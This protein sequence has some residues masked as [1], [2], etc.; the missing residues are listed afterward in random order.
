MSRIY[1]SERIGIQLGLSFSPGFNRVSGSLLYSNRFNGFSH[2]LDILDGDD[3]NRA[4]ETR[5]IQETVETVR[6]NWGRTSPG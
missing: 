4:V 2:T 5:A 3:S 6:K 1:D